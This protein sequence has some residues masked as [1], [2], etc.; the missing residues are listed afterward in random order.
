MKTSVGICYV[1]AAFMLAGSSVV[2]A[3]YITTYLPPYTI[4]FLSLA[5]AVATV[6]SFYGGMIIDAIGRISAK[7][8]RLLFLQ[9]LLGIVLFRVFLTFGLRHISAA[10]AGI[11]TGTAPAIT[12]LFAVAVLRDSITVHKAAGI[13]L[14]M[15]GMLILQGFPFN[16]VNLERE[17]IV[18]YVLVLAAT[19]CESFFVVLSRRMFM[20]DPEDD[21]HLHPVAH[22][23]I[24][25][26]IALVLCFFPMLTEASQADLF[27]VPPSGWLALAWYGAVVTILA[28]AFMFYG[29]KVCDGYTISALT[30][31]I[32][33]TS[34]ILSIVILGNDV[35]PHQWLGCIVIG[36]S[37]WVISRPRLRRAAA[38]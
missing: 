18:G 26:G 7:R 38:N 11:V 13:F 2:A 20:Q 31:V 23:G 5:F 17:H 15:L 6:V 25:S 34:V 21:E 14:T 27:A 24:V 16:A 3:R 28:F 19:A 35:Q 9:A 12:A 29:A 36:I 37:M 32:P 30:G 10:E 1:A 33:L 8:W 22:A 4:T